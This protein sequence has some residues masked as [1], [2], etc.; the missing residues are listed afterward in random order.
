MTAQPPALGGR[1]LAAWLG[2]TLA[3]IAAALGPTAIKLGQVASSRRDVL[4]A[5]LADELGRLQDRVRIPSAASAQRMLRP[6]LDQFGHRFVS[7]GK[8]AIGAGSVAVVFRGETRDGKS[9]AVKV[10]RPGVRGRM[11]RDLRAY[12]IAVRV[13]ARLPLLRAVPVVEMY[14]YL[15]GL[16]AMQCELE[17]EARAQ[18]ALRQ[19]L[20]RWIDIADPIDELCTPDVLVMPYLR[21][22]SKLTDTSL[23]DKEAKAA[24]VTLVRALYHMIFESGL[25]HCD[26]HPGNIS[27]GAGG[28]P[29]IYDFGLVGEL[30]HRDR[31]L[32]R[33]FFVGVA[34]EDVDSTLQ[35]ML[36]SARQLPDTLDRA[37]LRADVV[38]LIRRSTGRRAADFSVARFVQEVFE[39]QY[40]HRLFGSP[41]FASA[42]WAL[43]ILEGLVK[44]RHPQLDFQA[45]AAPYVTDAIIDQ[46]RAAAVG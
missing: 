14:D 35:S 43:A 28:R 42:I 17:R 7:I 29:I 37:A 22:A 1:R 46:M 19:A 34:M 25:V 9:V 21:G 11:R 8:E 30:S 12:R 36:A 2:K 27:I 10:I 39:I 5:S 41:P 26:L 6:Y 44:H 4:P 15:A 24:C 31:S 18:R 40:R 16:V 20:R 33:D 3:V 45:L 38:Q 32:F 13:A 23:A